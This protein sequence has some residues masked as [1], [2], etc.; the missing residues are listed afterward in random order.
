MIWLSIFWSVSMTIEAS[1]PRD[2]RK[3]FRDAMLILYVD[4]KEVT[5]ATIRVYQCV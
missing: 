4:N 3:T 5:C 2:L 1:L